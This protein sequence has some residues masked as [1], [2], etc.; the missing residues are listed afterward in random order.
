MFSIIFNRI[1]IG[2]NVY[3]A[4]LMLFLFK[5]AYTF[6]K[7]CLEKKIRKKDLKYNLFQNPLC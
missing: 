7:K 1:R 3:L 5:L 4:K 6:R 2:F